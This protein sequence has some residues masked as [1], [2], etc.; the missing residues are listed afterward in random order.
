MASPSLRPDVVR[1]PDGAMLPALLIGQR[2]GNVERHGK[3]LLLESRTPAT[4]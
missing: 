1:Y 4:T 2:F 3:Y